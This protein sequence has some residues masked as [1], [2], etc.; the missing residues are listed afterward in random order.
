MVKRFKDKL[1]EYT[2]DKEAEKRCYPWYITILKI[3]LAG[4]AFTTFLFVIL[5]MMEIVHD[6]KFIFIPF[7]ITIAYSFV[8]KFI[9]DQR[10]PRCSTCGKKNGPNAYR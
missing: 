10:I 8:F 3:I 9:H 7:G 4:L 2:Y 5:Y 6:V 1:Q